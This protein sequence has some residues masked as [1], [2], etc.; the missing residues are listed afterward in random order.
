MPHRGI[1]REA[2]RSGTILQCGQR[3]PW[4]RGSGVRRVREQAGLGTGVLCAGPQEHGVGLRVRGEETYEETATEDSSS[5]PRR[6]GGGRRG[7]GRAGRSLPR[8]LG[9][10]ALTFMPLSVPQPETWAPVCVRSAVSSPSWSLTLSLR[11]VAQEVG[12]NV[13]VV[14]P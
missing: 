2:E 1:P 6:L 5:W 10:G 12:A 8:P 14:G 3:A 9:L 7:E 13:L 11:G 4:C